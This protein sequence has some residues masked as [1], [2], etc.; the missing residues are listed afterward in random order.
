MH[1]HKIFSK[2]SNKC[3]ALCRFGL[4]EKQLSNNDV[5]QLSFMFN[6]MIMIMM[7]MKVV[8]TSNNDTIKLLIL[9][10]SLTLSL[11]TTKIF[12][13]VI[14]HNRGTNPVT[15]MLYYP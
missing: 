9:L 1:K 12:H 11:S 10:K 4:T 14:T 8:I 5:N 3:I 6:T 2:K 15:I 13:N 7:I